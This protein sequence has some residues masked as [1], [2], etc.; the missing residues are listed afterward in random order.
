MTG[1]PPGDR[2]DLV[3]LR[4][5]PGNIWAAAVLAVLEEAD[6]IDR[7]LNGA[8]IATP[9]SVKS[10]VDTCRRVIAAAKGLNRSRRDN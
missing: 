3:E 5:I 4:E 8:G 6:T 10:R 9:S 7:S 1:Q 2:L